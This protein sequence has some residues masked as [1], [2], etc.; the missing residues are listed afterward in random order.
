LIIRG[1]TALST[2]KM[3]DKVDDF[4]DI[5]HERKEPRP[6]FSK[7]LPRTK[8]PASIQETLDSEEKMW[9]K[10]YSDNK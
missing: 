7:P 5:P 9:D 8:L 4:K 3:P 10:L 1:P 6:D 2:V